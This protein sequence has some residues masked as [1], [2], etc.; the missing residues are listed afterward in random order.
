MCST[1]SLFYSFYFGFILLWSSVPQNIVEARTFQYS[2]VALLESSFDLVYRTPCA[3]RNAFAY[4]VCHTLS[5]FFVA[6]SQQFAYCSL[7]IGSFMQ[8]CTLFHLPTI[9]V[10]VSQPFQWIHFSYS[11]FSVFTARHLLTEYQ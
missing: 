2:R 10:L 4:L 8:Y 7:L 6:H 1:K 5:Y 11:L 3:P 9:A